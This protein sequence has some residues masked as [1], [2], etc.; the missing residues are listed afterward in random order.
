MAVQLTIDGTVAEVVLDRPDKLNAFDEDM[1]ADLSARLDEVEAAGCRALVLRGEGRG[2]SAGR[3]LAGLR[4]DEDA[5][6]WITT[7]VNG[8]VLRIA[9]LPI[10]TFAAVH[11]PALGVGFGLAFACDVVIAA[12]N[13][14]LGSPFANIGAVLDSGGHHVLVQRLGP[15]RALDLIYSARLITGA[16]AAAMGLVTASVPAE[17]LLEETRTR[18]AKAAAGPTAAF[19]ASKAIV[20]RIAEEGI[21]LAAVLAAEAAAQKAASSTADYREGMTAFVEKRTPAFEGR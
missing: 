10:P 12:D 11:G 1:S 6:A 13:A 7:Y 2:F 20:R 9:D 8:L 3:D 15:H 17:Q 14:R 18:A 5:E 19:A 4:L 21:G 16:D